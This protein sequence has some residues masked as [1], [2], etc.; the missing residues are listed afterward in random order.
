MNAR[1]TGGFVVCS[2]KCV[3]EIGDGKGSSSS[4]RGMEYSEQSRQSP[5]KEVASTDRDR[6]VLSVERLQF[7]GLERTKRVGQAE[8]DWMVKQR[9]KQLATS[10]EGE[11]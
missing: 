11:S 5:E 8:A 2:L 6:E 4:S 9:R 1:E 3:R 7:L 10:E